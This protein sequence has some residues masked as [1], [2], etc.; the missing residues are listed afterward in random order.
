MPSQSPKTYHLLCLLVMQI[1]FIE[2]QP[3]FRSRTSKILLQPFGPAKAI[4]LE[5]MAEAK[6]GFGNGRSSVNLLAW[7]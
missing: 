1:E 3:C 5:R 4:D 7:L 6:A 2:F